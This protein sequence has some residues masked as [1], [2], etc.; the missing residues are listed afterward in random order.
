MILNYRIISTVTDI[1][2]QM[3]LHQLTEEEFE[4]VIATLPVAMKKIKPD[5]I[6]GV[7][8]KDK[9]L[10]DTFYRLRNSVQKA[11]V[12]VFKPYKEELRKSIDNE[13]SCSSKSE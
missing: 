5:F 13:N 11:C 9:T 3:Y 4:T 10:D 7:D 12:E 1:L 6:L 8:D 2:M